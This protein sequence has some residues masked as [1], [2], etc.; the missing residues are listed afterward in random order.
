MVCCGWPAAAVCRWPSTSPAIRSP[1]C[2]PPPQISPPQ[3]A[4][5]QSPP[6][7]VSPARISPCDRLRFPTTQRTLRR[8]PAAQAGRTLW[9]RSLPDPLRPAQL[10]LAD[11]TT[12]APARSA[13]W[14]PGWSTGWSGPSSGR[15]G[16]ALPSSPPPRAAPRRPTAAMR[17]GEARQIRGPGWNAPAG[18]GPRWRKPATPPSTPSS[19]TP[20]PQHSSPI[21]TRIPR[22]HTRNSAAAR[23]RVRGRAHA[24]AAVFASYTGHNHYRRHHLHRP[25]R[26]VA[27]RR[28]RARGPAVGRRARRHRHPA[29]RLRARIGTGRGPQRRTLP[30]RPASRTPRETA[31]GHHHPHHHWARVE[32]NRASGRC[33]CGR[34]PPPPARHRRHRLG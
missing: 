7:P 34:C 1:P 27:A 4:P 21:P 6:P 9:C 31:R 17:G 29:H 30:R 8:R 3:N 32:R 33:A 24:V 19:A 5:P 26:A 20:P 18:T 14:A 2:S 10:P 22:R 15:C 11:T 25:D 12:T 28:L 13:P 23:R 16:N